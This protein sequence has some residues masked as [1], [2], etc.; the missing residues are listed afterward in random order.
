MPERKFTEVDL[1]VMVE[2]ATEW[3]PDHVP[4]DTFCG[5]HTRV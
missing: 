4:A 1:L 5:P 2:E 3:F